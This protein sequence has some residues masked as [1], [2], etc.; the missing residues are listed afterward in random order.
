M[1]TVQLD[2]VTKRYGQSHAIDNVSFSLGTGEFLTLLGPS[3][4]GKSTT[5]RAI[6][7]LVDVDEG[8]IVI[9]GRDVTRTPIYRRD[10]GMVF[11]N[12][13]LFPH[14]TVA[15]NIAFGLRMRKAD[16]ATRAKTVSHAL[17]L[18]R[19]PGFGERMPGQLSGG[20]Q[21]RVAIARALV[22]KPN[23]LLLDE[24]FAA[25][26]RKLREEMQSE[27]RG[28][29]SGLGITAIFVTHDQEE[30]LTLSDRVA[31]MNGGA[32]EQLGP[33]ET[34]FEQPETHFVADFMGARN[35]L[36]GVV[37]P[38]EGGFAHMRSGALS[39]VARTPENYFL[40]AGRP[41]TAAVRPESVRLARIGQPAPDDAL[42]AT[43]VSV[44][45]QGAY[46]TF[47]LSVEGAPAPIHSRWASGEAD[48]QPF[49]Q[50]ESL[51]VWWRPEDLRIL[52]DAPR[53][54]HDRRHTTASN[55][56]PCE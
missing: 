22:I 9:D 35:L 37:T 27:L 36:T 6:A 31:V 14:M 4:C 7:G 16:K 51:R 17:D 54:V 50:G 1:T 56:G 8:S 40:P 13:A 25:L 30:A 33:P 39:L 52:R 18:I 38:S 15:E 53:A 11:Q 45:Y 3:G 2:R 21:Q 46:R 29:T 23:V 12:L 41:V 28:L 5:L 20:Q 48:Q 42:S 26:D 24:P 10:I 47:E 19:L 55:K 32:I 43:V 49:R 44:V 34:V